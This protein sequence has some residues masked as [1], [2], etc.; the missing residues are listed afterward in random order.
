MRLRRRIKRARERRGATAL[1]AEF[2]QAQRRL[3][4][5][6]K[7]SKRGC[8]K[9]VCDEVNSDPWRIGYK[10]VTHRIGAMK[11]PEI[12]DARLINAIVNGLFPEHPPR[13]ETP[14]ESVRQ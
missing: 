10:I 1:N 8:W 3:R 5:V 7:D 14:Y 12:K 13:E 6:I 11:P 9:E 4:L 2:K